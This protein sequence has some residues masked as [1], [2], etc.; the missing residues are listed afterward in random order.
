[1]A[2]SEHKREAD[3]TK[4]SELLA[5]ETLDII[6]LAT[7]PGLHFDQCMRVLQSGLH[8]ICEKPLV[9]SLVQ[10]DEL[11]RPGRVIEVEALAGHVG[12]PGPTR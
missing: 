8:V 2:Q 9:S 6:D 7:P 12:Q 10:L 1:M 4:A 5:S 11:A 3:R